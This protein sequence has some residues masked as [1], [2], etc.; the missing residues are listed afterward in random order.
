MLPTYRND[1]IEQSHDP[2]NIFLRRLRYTR[3]LIELSWAEN[4]LDF[5]PY[6]ILNR[7]I[8]LSQEPI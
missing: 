3:S 6:T 1:F 4:G 2:V 5:D 7:Y 8:L